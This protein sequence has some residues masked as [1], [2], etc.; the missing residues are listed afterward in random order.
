MN[1]LRTTVQDNSSTHQLLLCLARVRLSPDILARIDSLLP[2]IDDWTPVIE[3]ALEHAV[4][5][6][7][8]HHLMALENDLIPGE[9]RDAA[10][11]FLDNNLQRNQRLL[12]EIL[13]ILQALTARGIPA[14]PFKGPVLAEQI[15]GDLAL[16]Y[17]R[18]LDFLVREADI[19]RV[20]E[21]LAGLG[22]G[23]TSDRT[24]AQERAF[25][26]YAGEYLFFHKDRD[27]AIEPHWALAPRT[28]AV[29]LDYEAL[30][31]RTGA[32]HLGGADIIGWGPEDMLLIVCIHGSKEMWSRL[33]WVCDVAELLRARPA[34]DWEALTSRARQGGVLRMLDIGLLL[35]H[36][37]LDAPLPMDV[38]A[39]ILA[40]GKAVRLTARAEARM[41]EPRQPDETIYEINSFRLLMRERAGDRRHYLLRTITTP[42]VQ[43]FGIIGFPDALFFLY[44]PLKLAH[45]YVAL[46]LWKVGKRLKLIKV[47]GPRQ[48]AD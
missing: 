28:L 19:D 42:R 7:V 14:V 5:P 20:L 15:Y 25:R 46:P 10:K 8:C 18:D 41:F 48:V 23:V 26:I 29:D 36:E 35:A 27:V 33:Q 12:G 45:D 6:L 30:W 47:D 34:L 24:P 37:M 43:H 2:E 1:D 22:Y 21:A 40:D 16:R 39:R 17:F 11:V 3:T 44:T 32:G 38:R 13:A 4:A 31:A 9:I